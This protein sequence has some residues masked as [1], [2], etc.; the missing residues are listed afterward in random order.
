[1]SAASDLQEFVAQA[2]EAQGV[3]PVNAPVIRRLEKDLEND[4]QAGAAVQNGLSVLVMRPIPTSAITGISKLFFDGYQV[5]VRLVEIPSMNNKGPDIYEMM[6]AVFLGLHWTNPG[7]M[8]AHPLMVDRRP[9]DVVE[10]AVAAP[11]F[12]HDGKF[13]RILDCLFKAVLQLNKV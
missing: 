2:L 9:V 4:I 7:G 11:G 8:L 13:I 6:D 3:L 1:M 10:G 5:R 12:E